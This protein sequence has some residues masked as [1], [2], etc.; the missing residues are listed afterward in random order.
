M[1]K[2]KY[3]RFTYNGG[4]VTELKYEHYLINITY[5]DAIIAIKETIYN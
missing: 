5:W 2:V 3:I 1:K 4:K